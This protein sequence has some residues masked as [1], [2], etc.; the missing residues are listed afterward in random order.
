MVVAALMEV[1][2][3]VFLVC[4]RENFE[5][6]KKFEVINPRI[7]ANFVQNDEEM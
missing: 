2:S 3:E 7:A 5:N 1:V 4:A 6:N